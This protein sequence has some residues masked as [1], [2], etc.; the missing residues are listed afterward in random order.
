MCG[1]VAYI[2]NGI[3][4]GFLLDALK[5]L[6]YRGYDSAGI[7]VM[8]ELGDIKIKKS[9]GKLVNLINLVAQDALQGS[10]GIGHTRWATHG[11][12]NDTN[13]HPHA[14]N[15]SSV[16]LVHNG[17]IS[18]YLE[19]KD[20]L[21][22]Q[23]GIKFF[24]ET[25]T[26]VIA[27]LVSVR[28]KQSN[29]LREALIKAIDELQGSYALCVIS[30]NEKNKILLTC[31]D[32]PLIIGK[33]KED[34]AL[35]CAS[36]SAALIE[37]T[38]KIIRLKDHQIA[39]LRKDG[40]FEIF[41]KDGN[42]CEIN[43]Q[44][45][46]FDSQILDK[47]GFRHY[48]L[49]EIHEQPAIIRKLF[50]YHFDKNLNIN[51]PDLDPKVL[52][53][54]ERVLII[55]CG[56]AYY[57]GMVGKFLLENLAQVPCDIEFSSEILSKNK[58]LVDKNTL[59]V[60]ISQSGETAD[61]LSA[62][63][64][65]L[66]GRLLAVNNRPESTLAH[67]AQ[68]ACVFTQAGIEVS[69]A[70]TKSFTAQIF[71]FYCL[72]IYLAEKKCKET[73][74]TDEL[75]KLQWLKKQLHYQPQ[76]MEQV[77]NKAEDYKQKILKHSD[78]KSFVFLGRGINYPIALEGALKLKELTYVQATGYA[79]GEMK[80]GPIATL[81]ESVPVIALLPTGYTNNKTLH[82]A[83]E[84][85]TRGAPFLAITNESCTEIT[86]EAD[87][88]FSLPDLYQEKLGDDFFEE[89]LNPFCSVIPLQLMAYYLAEHMGKDVDQPR[90]LAKSVTV[91]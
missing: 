1:I 30:P 29:N 46:S 4:A 5:T 33:A 53:K 35:F 83:M 90:N 34:G 59:V 84:A 51:F 39:E 79:S 12:P 57:A 13:A 3:A 8:N 91:E 71:S 85:K 36:D 15:D 10:I 6:E 22:K 81:D 73:R 44:S 28:L 76:V 50:N 14:S 58:P 31:K 54:V 17:I 61:T 77:L 37:Y 72:A 40:E 47:K 67:L 42:P 78:K 60:A 32:A 87:L 20:M 9:E 45:L 82:N 49:K 69:V 27:N 63:K 66:G 41:T 26:E 48:L 62:V 55:G 16:I 23:H 43:L 64:K 7:A 68:N 21:I 70:A 56:T 2:G 52:D 24:S 38:D 75:N 25:D 88:I 74:N 19:I 89:L 86:R 80:H 18:N 65:T 11:V